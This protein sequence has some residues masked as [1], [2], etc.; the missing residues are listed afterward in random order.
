MH[1][2]NLIELCKELDDKYDNRCTV[3]E[4]SIL[5]YLLENGETQ[6]GEIGFNLRIGQ[7]VVSRY[8][9]KMEVLGFVLRDDG[10]AVA[11]S[12]AKELFNKYLS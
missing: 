6:V 9:K 3:R 12:K 11:T 8:L 10:K 7:P 5:L 2:K 4:V 1:L